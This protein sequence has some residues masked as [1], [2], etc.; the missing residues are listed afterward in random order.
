LCEPYN[1]EVAD[2]LARLAALG[3]QIFV[4]HG[5][6]DFMLGA[7][8][9][10]R[11]KVTLVAEPHCIQLGDRRVALMHA[12]VLCTDDVQYMRY[13]AWSRTPW[14]QA[15]FRCLPY[16]LRHRV[17]GRIRSTSRA[18]KSEKSQMI[19]DVNAHAVTQVFER[20]QAD[21]LIHGHTHRPARHALVVNG[22]NCERIVLP[23]WHDQAVWLE[24]D[25]AA[26]HDRPQQ[27]YANRGAADTAA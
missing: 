1:A 20:T 15:V 17:A 26:F 25:G 2:A 23:D 18:E 7:R 3:T 12:D 4:F 5:N 8:F 13:R 24:W 14:R 22:R 6:R 21:I 9:A 11:A 16:G 10:R 19:M 27:A